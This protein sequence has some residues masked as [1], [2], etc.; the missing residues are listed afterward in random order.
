MIALVQ[1]FAFALKQE[2]LMVPT[3]S[4]LLA[5]EAQKWINPLDQ[6]QFR[7][8]LEASLVIN[9]AD[10]PTF[11]RVYHRYFHQQIPVSLTQ[12]NQI[13][14]LNLKDFT[15]QL[16]KEG[17]PV[18]H[19]LADYIE[20]QT[21]GLMNR[22][23]LIPLEPDHV[24]QEVDDPAKADRTPK[25]RDS[26]KIHN[27]VR[28]LIELA[29]DFSARSFSMNRE[30]RE[31]LT[32]YLRQRLEEAALLLDQNRPKPKAREILPWEKKRT[33]S[34]ISFNQLTQ[35]EIERVK[36]EVER[37][38]QKLKDALSAKRKRTHRGHIEIKKTIRDSLR[39]GGVPFYIHHKSP[40][41]T[42]G[43]VVALCDIS[44]S[45]SYAAQFMIL[46]LY[47]LQNRFSKIRTFVFIRHTYEI[48]R[49]FEAYPMETALVKATKDHHIGMGQP[50]NYGT[51]FKSF[52]DT[53]ESA[54]TKDTTLL[55]L[56]DGQN[57]FNNPMTEP[58]EKMAKKVERVIWLNPEEEKFWYSSSNSLRHYKP[59]CDQVIECATLDQLGEFTR[60][61]VL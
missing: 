20:G 21:D 11:E 9:Q 29:E 6:E 44:S 46:L 18:N 57:N 23:G 30:K 51:S 16:R 55:I 3:N 15:D 35:Q 26:Q 39:Y 13:F 42:K 5:I 61:L 41:K 40:S 7:A 36:E 10:Q 24:P 56:G 28:V 4:L 50:S 31:A 59:F 58:F 38:A 34:S 19:I 53:Y 14:K 48:S 47:R 17:D 60:N 33:L 2:G 37:L 52:L 1:Q 27:R 49:Y 32:A 22:L 54:L 8:A 43:K 25:A 45:V 12:E